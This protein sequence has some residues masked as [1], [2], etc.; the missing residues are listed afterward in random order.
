MAI[1]K[2]PLSFKEYFVLDKR[3]V[4][5]GIDLNKYYGESLVHH[6]NELLELNEEVDFVIFHD[7]DLDGAGASAQF[8]ELLN[9]YKTEN[10]D[11]K[12]HLVSVSH[13]KPFQKAITEDL[14]EVLIVLRPN[15][16]RVFIVLDQALFFSGYQKLRDNCQKLFW[17][18]HHPVDFTSEEA[19]HPFLLQDD[20]F[21][22]INPFHSTTMKVHHLFS[23]S[24]HKPLRNF[25]MASLEISATIDYYDTWQFTE[26]KK[27]P[28]DLFATG[29]NAWFFSQETVQAAVDKVHSFYNGLFLYTKVGH[30]LNE[31][32]EAIHEGIEIVKVKD[33]IGQAAMRKTQRVIWTHEGIEYPTGIIFHSDDM[34]DLAD[35]LL[36]KQSDLKVAAIIYLTSTGRVKFS[37]RAKRPTIINGIAKKMG[38]GGSE[39]AAGAEIQITELSKYLTDFNFDTME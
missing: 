38:G 37:I 5:S 31:F 29:L 25:A 9:Y 21:L 14:D 34:S 4:Q 7:S 24:G 35:R 3:M 11:W 1:E 19:D 39:Q 26:D 32:H 36:N 17:I 6:F 27:D 16:A 13:G 15:V 12:H 30:R 18:D 2:K 22:F 8:N 33:R 28:M 20:T 10:S 23:N